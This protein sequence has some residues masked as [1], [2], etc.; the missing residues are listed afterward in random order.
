MRLD[1]EKSI[2]R[3]FYVTVLASAFDFVFFYIM[4]IL[5]TGNFILENSEAYEALYYAYNF[6]TDAISFVLPAL[7]VLYLIPRAFDVKFIKLMPTALYL[8]APTAIFGVIKYYIDFVL[9]HYSS[10]EAI[11]ISAIISL[12]TLAIEALIISL[13]AL[14]LRRYL[15]K[16]GT[17]KNSFIHND[18]PHFDIAPPAAFSVFIICFVQFSV[19]L[20]FEIISTVSFF[21]DI[22]ESYRVDE[23][24]YIIMRF[25][26]IVAMLILTH[27]LLIF[28]KNRSAVEL[29]IFRHNR[30]DDE[31]QYK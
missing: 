7:A 8:C 15:T 4:Y 22:G 26:F 30:N 10:I 11:I 17:D 5:A 31:F 25:V 19:S 3:L 12:L 18:V 9:E 13:M 14:V 24:I 16:H 1:G 27:A 20:I 29:S 28:I 23:L 2:K 21:I 6:V